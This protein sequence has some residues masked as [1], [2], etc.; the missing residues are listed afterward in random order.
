[1]D[2]YVYMYTKLKTNCRCSKNIVWKYFYFFRRFNKDSISQFA[3]TK[4]KIFWQLFHGSDF[5]RTND[6]STCASPLEGGALKFMPGSRSDN[7]HIPVF[8]Y[9]HFDAFL[10]YCIGLRGVNK[11]LYL[12]QSSNIKQ[13]VSM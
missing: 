11:R 4:N 8:I 6:S 7:L 3:K 1:M 13:K 10:Y 12:L 2:V 9:A 5:E